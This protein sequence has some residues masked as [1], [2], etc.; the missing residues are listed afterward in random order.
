MPFN[1]P[2]PE[3]NKAANK[4]EQFKL[5]EGW[6]A[7]EKPPASIFN[8]FFNTVYEA[9]KE[10]QDNGHT[11]EEI[12]AF[13]AT[14]NQAITSHTNNKQNPHNVTVTQIGAETPA[15]SKAKADAAEKNAKDASAPISHVG[16]GGTEHPNA[17][18]TVSG[19]MSTADKTKLD[20]VDIGANKYVHPAAHPPSII[21]QD[22]SNRFVTDTEKA[23]WNGKET[24]IGAKAKADAA[25]KAAIDFAKSF[26]L[27][28]NAKVLPNDTDINTIE[29][30][31]FYRIGN[32]VNGVGVGTYTLIV[33]SSGTIQTQM[34]I[35]VNTDNTNR[36]FSRIKNAGVWTNWNTLETLEGS[37][38]KSSAA[39]KN[40]VDFAKKYGLGDRAQ[41]LEVETDLNAVVITGF[42]YGWSNNINRPSDNSHY[43]IVMRYSDT[44]VLQIATL[45]SST[46]TMYTRVQI[47]GVWHPWRQVET[48]AG[49]Q[50]K[51]DAAESNAISV[52]RA[53]A[54]E[55][56]T[57]AKNALI[58]AMNADEPPSKYPNGYSTFVVGTNLTGYPYV[59]STIE[60]YKQGHTRAFQFLKPIAAGG[61]FYRNMTGG[62]ED[63][64][65]PWNQIETV[66]NSDAKIRD[67]EARAKAHAESYV[68]KN[69]KLYNFD[70]RDENNPPSSYSRGLFTEFK[71]VST[72]GLTGV[73]G[74]YCT[75][76]TDGRW[77]GTSGGRKTQIALTDD[78]RIYTRIGLADDSAWGVWATLETIVGAQSKADKAETNA[79]NHANT[80]L[81]NKVDKETGKGLSTNDYTAAEK[82]KLA[83]IATSANNYV[84]PSTHPATII[85]QTSAYRF[86]SDAEKA[87]W[88]K[89]LADAQ[90]YAM[91]M[92][93]SGS[94][95][96]PNT[97]QEAYILTNHANSPGLGIY[98]HIQTYFYSNKT[99][100]RSQMAISYS[101]IDPLVFVRHT[102]GGTTT[103]WTQ[104]ASVADASATAQIMANTAESN[105]IN[106]ARQ[107]MGY[108]I[109]FNAEW[110]D[111]PSYGSGWTKWTTRPAQYAKV[112]A[113]VQ[114]RGGMLGGSFGDTYTAFT[115]PSGFRPSQTIALPVSSV[116]NGSA[117]APTNRIV[118]APDGK[119][120]VSWN[121][122]NTVISLDGVF[123]YE[124]SQG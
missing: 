68:D 43:L 39:E 91:N 44:H 3:W 66:G 118:I 12:A 114:L 79:K 102:Y 2:L 15:G 100:N 52:A 42:Y 40:A 23:N 14:V 82:T 103:K 69:N 20:G 50:A 19:F 104:I 29:E 37:K 70:S 61:L 89:T 7:E 54:K 60:T 18:P 49:S 86:V 116:A 17:T 32:P 31:G 62:G 11:K 36:V 9:L 121:Q 45:A 99:G 80:A 64:W 76:L 87:V 10:L 71:S 83:G 48:T 74:N 58:P 57:N 96:D 63:L 115:L 22:A 5:D 95:A 119:V 1:K 93:A 28:S 21:V 113:G 112:G 97:T 107:D 53:A 4:P 46:A 111:V 55:A 90:S 85:A 75:V 51:A 16:K 38:A 6:S 33:I 88:N 26:G 101:G 27:G 109:G 30:S 67:V 92:V 110:R 105:A 98:W 65:T 81:A 108:R 56:E 13:L 73:S 35:G 72:M 84:H 59:Y 120:S 34:L 122:G 123:F 117:E 106:Q 24:P 77:I 25:E 94:S 78:G 8:W 124:N 47:N 41:L